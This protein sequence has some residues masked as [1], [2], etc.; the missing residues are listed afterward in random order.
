MATPPN[1][2][3]LTGPVQPNDIV[4]R[5][6]EIGTTIPGIASLAMKSARKGAQRG[7]QGIYQLPSGQEPTPEFMNVSQ[8]NLNNQTMQMTDMLNMMAPEDEQLA[9]INEEEAGILKLLGGSGEMTPQGIPTYKNKN[10]DMS[11]NEQRRFGIDKNLLKTEVPK[12]YGV[13][14]HKV[15]LAYITEPEAE[16]LEELDLYDSNPPHEGPG[17]IPNYNDSGGSGTGMGGMGSPGDRGG[18]ADRAAA[19]AAE[20]AAAEAEAKAKRDMQQLIAEAEANEANNQ[21]NGG[22]GMPAGFV[23]AEGED[24][25]TAAA[26]AEKAR[27]VTDGSGNAVTNTSPAGVTTNV[28]FGGPRTPDG[29]GMYNPNLIG[30]YFGYEN[31]NYAAP[32]ETTTSTESSGNAQED[33]VNSQIEYAQDLAK[34]GVSRDR[35]YAASGLN[36]YAGGMGLDSMTS[37][38]VLGNMGM[39]EGGRLNELRAKA[40]AN[41]LEGDE[42]NELAQL[43]EFYGKNPTTGMGFLESLEYQVTNPEFVEGIKKVGP[44]LGVAAITA[45]APAS[46]KLAM[47]AYNLINRF[48]KNPLPSLRTTIENALAKLGNKEKKA[49]AKSLPST[50]KGFGIQGQ[51]GGGED[52]REATANEAVETE[53]IRREEEEERAREEEENNRKQDRFQRSFANR[54]FVGP[55]SLDAVRKYAT[56]EGGYNQLTPFS[57]REV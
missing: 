17:G 19:R 51:G 27:T 2:M 25:A 8:Q 1:Q 41:T 57:G 36:S 37:G 54:Y 4:M 34:K 42:L 23:E 16:I 6:S 5:A 31:P 9:Y 24:E 39:E 47:T 3:G 28:T 14:E 7:A 55:A 26:V 18:I 49:V 50:Y 12:F 56:T 53:R 33:Y 11:E 35:A 15:K 52:R 46:A 43:N 48:R 30:Q 40:K 10:Q 13:G 20:A 22:S 44:I 38:G 32:G 21:G 29:F 45:L